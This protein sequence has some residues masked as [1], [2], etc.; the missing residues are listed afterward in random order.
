VSK[1]HA[2]GEEWAAA[3]DAATEALNVSPADV[4]GTIALADAYV[5]AE[6]FDEVRSHWVLPLGPIAGSY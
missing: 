1:A 3:A 6:N 4:D 5:G 2:K